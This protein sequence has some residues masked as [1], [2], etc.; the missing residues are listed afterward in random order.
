MKLPKARNENLLEQN[1]EKETLIYDLLIDKAFNLNETL[2]VVY[3]AC[4]QNHTFDDLKRKHK[5]SDEFIYLALD[6]LKRNTLLAGEYVSP[7]ETM[8]RREV[9]KKV[10]L[11]TMFALPLIAGLVAPRAANAASDGTGN[12]PGAGVTLF[13][14]C[15]NAGTPNANCNQDSQGRILTCVNGTICCDGAYRTDSLLPGTS[16]TSNGCVPPGDMYYCDNSKC[17]SN[18]VS[19]SCSVAPEWTPNPQTGDYD[20]CIDDNGGVY[21]GTKS[22]CNC[23]CS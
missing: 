17:C 2:S 3:K 19:G 1:F 18:E 13:G 21:A 20:Y 9:I 23:T 15:A 16:F 11:T 6:E 12:P 8:N 14:A 10:G 4:G 22:T 7:F 5:F